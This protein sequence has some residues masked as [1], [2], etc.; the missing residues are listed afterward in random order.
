MSGANRIEI[1]S[2]G[3][4]CVVFYSVCFIFIILLP[5]PISA[6]DISPFVRL[7]HEDVLSQVTGQSSTWAVDFFKER[8]EVK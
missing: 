3:C 6:L 4:G 1:K 5:K 8:P 2:Q 7:F